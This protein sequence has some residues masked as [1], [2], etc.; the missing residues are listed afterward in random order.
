[1]ANLK[2]TIPSTLSDSH[3]FRLC[4]GR[5]RRGGYVAAQEGKQDGNSFSFELNFTREGPGPGSRRRDTEIEGG[6]LTA[7]A[8]AAA[9]KRLCDQLH[10]EGLTPT[11]IDAATIASAIA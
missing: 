6:R 7:K 1:M 8:I 4:A 5:T 3:K 2:L 11:P 10:A 9:A